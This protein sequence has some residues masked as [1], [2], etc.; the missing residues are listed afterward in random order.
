MSCIQLSS[1]STRRL[2]TN[3]TTQRFE[4]L[5]EW[6]P[7]VG[8]DYVRCVYKV[9]GSSGAQDLNIQPAYQVAAVR[10]NSPDAPTTYGTGYSGNGEWVTANTDISAGTAS[11][12]YIRF[13]LAYKAAAAGD[14][15]ADV[16]MQVCAE[17]YGKIVATK[18]LS[19]VAP[20]TADRYF[21]P[22]SGWLPS[23]MV[24]KVKAALV[25]AQPSANFKAAL[26]YQLAATSVENPGAWS[27]AG[28][29]YGTGERNTGEQAVTYATPQ[30]MWIRL[31]VKCV[32]DAGVNGSGVV[33]V[34]AGIRK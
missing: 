31:G 21:T 24:T 27:M 9:K 32:M 25:V 30:E 28:S 34:S 5:T 16:T 4:Y 7:A 13:G 6:M 10:T 29:E 8:M 18:T 22:I 12:Q 1:E 2:N 15:Q 23:S 20:D 17:V 11:Y 26:A 3:S 33:T 14:A 19:L